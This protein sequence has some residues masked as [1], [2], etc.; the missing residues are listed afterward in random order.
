M[1][2]IDLK[3][4]VL[5]IPLEKPFSHQ[6][7]RKRINPI[8]VHLFLDEGIEGIGLA[9]TWNDEQVASLKTSIEDLKPIVIGQDP[10]F[11][12]KVWHNLWLATRHMGHTGHGIYA[13]SAIDMALWE[14]K[15]KF[16]GL[17]VARLLGQ[18]RDKVPA[19]ASHKLFRPWTLEE[20]QQDAAE[21]VR[22]G[23]RA[24]KMNLGD[25]KPAEE[26]RRVKA[27]RE[28]VGAEIDILIDV[29]WA[30]TPSQ[31][32][33]MARRLESFNI[34]WLED[35]LASEDVDD[36][37]QLAQALDMP[38]ATGE[39]FC[40]K[41]GFRPLLEKRA[42]DILIVDVQRVGGI[43]EFMKVAAMAQAWHRPIAS[44]LFHDFSVHL[45]AAIPNGLLVE[46][47]PWWD[48]IYAEPL[49]VKDGMM[50]VPEVPGWGLKLNPSALEKY[51]RS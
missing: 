46:Y 2:I 48:V 15:A 22:Q 25:K 17:P 42:A 18:F 27:V 14:L 32:I 20:L 30:W 5:S 47:M 24:M 49:Q 28:V 43:T 36:L 40:T 11:H 8:I 7:A 19:Y 10:F 1:K 9:F 39:T 16:L 41:Y 33:E 6:A 51:A 12:E 4:T 35:P 37:A 38:I 3:T 29:N 50:S 21:L 23:F 26:I 44:H 13:L 31:A 45:I 34:Y